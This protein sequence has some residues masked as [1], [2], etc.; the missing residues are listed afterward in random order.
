MAYIVTETE[1]LLTSSPTTESIRR[2]ARSSAAGTSPA[3]PETTLKQSPRTSIGRDPRYATASTQ[4][5]PSPSSSTRP[6]YLERVHHL[7]PSTAHR[8]RWMI[9]HYIVPAIGHLPLRALRAEHLERLYRDLRT[10]GRTNGTGLAPKTV[11]DVHVIMPLRAQARRAYSSRR[12]QRRPGRRSH[13]AQQRERSKDPSRGPSTSSGISSPPR[14]TSVSTPPFTSPRSTGMRRGE[15]AGL[16][17]GDWNPTTH[18]IS[19]SPAPG[20]SIAGRT[21][22]VSRQDDEPVAAASTS[23]R[24]TEA[25]LTH[26]RTS[27]ATRRTPEPARTIRSSRTPHGD[28]RALQSPISQ[29]FAR[30]R[31]DHR[32]ARRSDFTTCAT[33]T[34]HSSPPVGAPR[35]R[36]SPN[37]SVTRTPDSPWPPINT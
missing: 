2:P 9:D 22:E 31:Q 4:Q 24:T 23:T 17:W 33:P 7:R 29:L 19:R 15:V 25:V 36:S 21:T 8:Y 16:R 27:P 28:A 1:P 26:W 20:K 6:G 10:T 12:A 30:Q 3:S 37:D 13:P 35:S 34:P 32:P 18:A 5:R 14:D 11:Y